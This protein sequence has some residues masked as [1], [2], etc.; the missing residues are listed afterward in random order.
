MAGFPVTFSGGP[1]KA[2]EGGAPLGAHNREILG[3]LI[4]G[5][6]SGLEIR[7]DLRYAVGDAGAAQ[8]TEQPDG[9]GA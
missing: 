9:R 8:A 4:G 6:A 2:L 7:A 5:E 3:D 1:L